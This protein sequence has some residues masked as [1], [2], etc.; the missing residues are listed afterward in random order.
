MPSFGVG[1]Y[2]GRTYTPRHDS[3][4]VGYGDVIGAE[5]TYGRHVSPTATGLDYLREAE[6][7]NASD[8][9][10]IGADEARGIYAKQLGVPVEQLD[11]ATGGRLSKKIGEKNVLKTVNRDA[12]RF[13]EA[14]RARRLSERGPQGFLGSG[15]R[16]V[17]AA[18]AELTDP[19]SMAM[20]FL[21]VIREGKYL[22]LVNK[23]G[24]LKATTIQGVAEGA[25]GSILTEPFYAIGERRVNVEDYTTEDFFYNVL[26]GVVISTGMHHTIGSL[27][28]L[29]G[30]DRTVQARKYAGINEAGEL[31]LSLL[32]G[33]EA[34]KKKIK[35]HIN[36]LDNSALDSKDLKFDETLGF[37]KLIE[38]LGDLARGQLP[39]VSYNAKAYALEKLLK[40]PKSKD[41]EVQRV[42]K[43]LLEELVEERGSRAIDVN[44]QFLLRD[45]EGKVHSRNTP[46]KAKP[47]KEVIDD[48]NNTNSPVEGGSTESRRAES[49]SKGAE[50]FAGSTSEGP[51]VRPKDKGE[52]ASVPEDAG[53]DGHRAALEAVRCLT[54]GQKAAEAKKADKAAKDKAKGKVKEKPVRF[55]KDKT[56]LSEL[57]A[58]LEEL[59]REDA[60]RTIDEGEVLSDSEVFKVGEELLEQQKEELEAEQLDEVEH[61]EESEAFNPLDRE[62]LQAVADDLEKEVELG[63][64][65]DASVPDSLVEGDVE[66]SSITEGRVFFPIMRFAATLKREFSR[67]EG[68][69]LTRAEEVAGA[70]NKRIGELS[71]AS[72]RFLKETQQ[73]IFSAYREDVSVWADIIIALNKFSDTSEMRILKGLLTQ[74]R[75]ADF[76]RADNLLKDA[77][78]L[79]ELE[80]VLLEGPAEKDGSGPGSGVVRKERSAKEIESLASSVR[81]TVEGLQVLLS[82]GGHPL[83]LLSRMEELVEKNL[84]KGST[85]SNILLARLKGVLGA[86]E[87][88]SIPLS[89]SGYTVGA[90]NRTAIATQP[91]ASGSVSDSTPLKEIHGFIDFESIPYEEAIKHIS[92]ELSK[93]SEQMDLAIE[94]QGSASGIAQ[95]NGDIFSSIEE[96]LR[97][98]FKHNPQILDIIDDLVSQGMSLSKLKDLVILAEGGSV[99]KIPLEGPSEKDGTDVGHTV[100]RSLV[101]EEG[102]SPF[103]GRVDKQLPQDASDARR[104]AFHIKKFIRKTGLVEVVRGGEENFLEWSSKYKE[105]LA[106]LKKEIGENTF[107]MF[108]SEESAFYKKHVYEA[109]NSIAG[110]ENEVSTEVLREI[111]AKSIADLLIRV[112]LIEEMGPAYTN[113]RRGFVSDVKELMDTSLSLFDAEKAVFEPEV[114][115]EEFRLADELEEAH[116]YLDELTKEQMVIEDKL[117]EDGKP[118]LDEDGKPIQV[119]RVYASVL[120]SYHFHGEDDSIKH[121]TQEENHR[122]KRSVYKK[123]ISFIKQK[124][125][126]DFEGLA[127]YFEELT[128]FNPMKAEHDVE[129]FLLDSIPPQFKDAIKYLIQEDGNP[130][131]MGQLLGVKVSEEVSGMISGFE[132][133]EKALLKAD[134]K[135]YLGGDPGDITTVTRV[136]IPSTAHKLINSSK[137]NDV[138]GVYRILM[139]K[140]EAESPQILSDSEVLRAPIEVAENSELQYHSSLSSFIDVFYDEVLNP[141]ETVTFESVQMPDGTVK[142]IPIGETP[143]Y[144]VPLLDVLRAMGIK[145]VES[146]YDGKGYQLYAEEVAAITDRSKT[147]RTWIKKNYSPVREQD[148]TKSLADFDKKAIEKEEREKI[149]ETNKVTIKAKVKSLFKKKDKRPK[150]TSSVPDGLEDILLPGVTDYEM[151]QPFKGPGNK[152]HQGLLSVE[153]ISP[154]PPKKKKKKKKKDKPAPITYGGDQQVS[155]LSNELLGTSAEISKEVEEGRKKQ[156]EKRQARATEREATQRKEAE[157]RNQERIEREASRR[158]QLFFEWPEAE[159]SAWREESKKKR[160]EFADRQEISRERDKVRITESATEEERSKRGATERIQSLLASDEVQ[161]RFWEVVED[162]DISPEDLP[163]EVQILLEAQHSPTPL[164]HFVDFLYIERETKTPTMIRNDLM[165]MLE[166]SIVEEDLVDTDLASNIMVTYIDIIDAVFDGSVTNTRKWKKNNE[167][168]FSIRKPKI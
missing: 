118:V 27:G 70:I 57:G 23:Y 140:I 149:K 64:E 31:D 84:S 132:G 125:G 91:Q 142:R 114:T 80:E 156:V 110:I 40:D 1:R 60:L 73:R 99:S 47:L 161:E 139:D 59:E 58:H 126:P 88:D 72:H 106:D 89:G 160:Q 137:F 130:T 83:E 134:L 131:R 71:V 15:A 39:D 158:K 78:G 9:E 147:I 143:R 42:I 107:T 45:S 111:G 55:E 11:Q 46:E 146:R 93:L 26:A 120:D 76:D 124:G 151:T 145:D 65:Q 159:E 86:I 17:G 79:G 63:G 56:E 32:E 128:G 85:V 34:L 144:D 66:T 162:A 148:I 127:D 2:A 150:Y 4:R 5:F 33:S 10:F 14:F 21:P 136:T 61:F 165:R 133:M 123:F 112:N 16:F 50:A 51:S 95:L 103:E 155:E 48:L 96:K 101:K 19:F 153:E 152:T 157:K 100:K 98:Q 62:A 44:N 77:L 166:E 119:A 13:A 90:R 43:S 69:S 141:F 138:Y 129:S 168:P 37:N 116:T 29:L 74:V 109:R 163:M 154:R 38:A 3:Y 28:D 6:E 68:W 12:Y 35:N 105:A 75:D 49:A 115:P 117:D 7:R 113:E 108:F 82:E 41:P 20:N 8:V 87:R 54:A 30:Q 135:E 22:R 97:A 121:L 104:I 167:I 53:D 92:S 25:V 81:T 102:L 122:T 36:N 52:S 94:A 164:R 24:K 18:G 67:I